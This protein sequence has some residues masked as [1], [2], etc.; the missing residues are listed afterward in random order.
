M[1]ITVSEFQTMKVYELDNRTYN[2]IIDKF[3]TVFYG[4]EKIAKSFLLKCLEHT[5]SDLTCNSYVDLMDC[6]T[7]MG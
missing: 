2:K 4:N 6:F 1:F 7:I 3:T 5:V